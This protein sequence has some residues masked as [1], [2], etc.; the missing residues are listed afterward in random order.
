MNVLV[1]ICLVLAALPL[2]MLLIN[3]LFYRRPRTPAGL[4]IEKVSI[5]IPARNEQDNIE[6]AIMAALNSKG[7]DVEVVVLDDGST[8]DTAAIVQRLA[9]DDSRV[10]L[11]QGKPLPAGWMGKNFAC[12]QLAQ[13]ATG[14]WLLFQDADVHLSQDAV[15]RLA[16]HAQNRDIDLLSGVPQQI[17]HSLGE[18]LIIPLINLVLLGYLPMIGVRLTRHPMFAAGVGQFVLA[19]RE[20]YLDV[21]GHGAIRSQIQDGVALPRAFR[22]KGYFSD[23]A[24]LTGLVFCRMY[25]DFSQVWQGFAK[26]AHEGMGS[27]GAIG[28]WTTL[29]LGGHVLP[30]VGAAVSA[31][32][33][34][35]ETGLFLAAGLLSL[36]ARAISALRFRQNLSGVLLHPVGMLLIVMIQWYGLFRFKSRNPIAWKGRLPA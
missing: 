15:S 11:I 26:N 16:G 20:A 7:V 10:R 33:G 6:Q 24:D 14:H 29:L 4:S 9:A 3:L 36:V 1:I 2:V 23:L 13:A 18:R 31:L 8:D 22:G 35:P 12:A 34:R 21:G 30:W 5:L 27:P 25:Q 28:V 19:R 17:T 32:L